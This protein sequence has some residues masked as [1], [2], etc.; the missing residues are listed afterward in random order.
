MPKVL[1]IHAKDDTI[2]T[3]P[4]V[5]KFAKLTGSHIKVLKKDGHFSTSEIAKKSFWKPI[6][7]FLKT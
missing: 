5:A 4:A 1:I 3:L 7:K 6:S 2:V